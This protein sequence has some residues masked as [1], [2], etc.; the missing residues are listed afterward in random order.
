MRAK[1][2]V[3]V[4][5]KRALILSPSLEYPGEWRVTQ[6]DEIGPSGHTDHRTARDAFRHYRRELFGRPG[7]KELGLRPQPPDY[8]KAKTEPPWLGLSVITNGIVEQRG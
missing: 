6:W 7:C 1:C 4:D 5:D 3:H 8:R 2:Y